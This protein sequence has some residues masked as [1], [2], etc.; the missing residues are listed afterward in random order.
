VE[1]L[2]VSGAQADFSGACTLR[3]GNPF[4]FAVHVE[5]H[6]DP[7]TV[8]RFKITVFN[9]NGNLIHQSDSTLGGGTIQV[10]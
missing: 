7:G 10:H 4:R 2:T 6:G 9:R 3:N 1:R 5:D 8:D